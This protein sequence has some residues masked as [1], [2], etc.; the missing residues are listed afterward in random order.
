MKKV[1]TGVMVFIAIT[2]NAQT[3][4]KYMLQHI[5]ALQVYIGYAKKGY[6]IASK[7]INTVRNIKNGDFNLHRDFFSSLK[8][9]NPAIMNAANNQVEEWNA[10][11]DAKTGP[12]Q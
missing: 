1:F 8:N 6:N 12:G 2:S 5:A 3:Q 9:I 7:G 10:G 11:K 4:K